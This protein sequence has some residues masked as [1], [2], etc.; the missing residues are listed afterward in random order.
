MENK[1]FDIIYVDS[2]LEFIKKRI[3]SFNDKVDLFVL[4]SNNPIN[5]NYFEEFNSK[6]YTIID[7][8]TTDYIKL[9]ESNFTKIV[10][11]LSPNHLDVFLVSN[12]NEVPDIDLERYDIELRSKPICHF[13]MVN[14]NL[15]QF[16]MGTVVFTF[17][18]FL[19]VT[20]FL[21]WITDEKNK[22]NAGNYNKIVSGTYYISSELTETQ[23][24]YDCFVFN[25]ELDLLNLRL[26]LLNEKVTKF[27]LVES[28]KSHSGEDKPL[29]FQEN[30]HLFSEYLSKITHIIVD[31]F[32][33][34]M[35]YSP[36]E[37]DVDPKLHIHWFRE[38]YQRNEILKGLYQESIHNND[39]I[40]ISD[41]DEIPDPEKLSSFISLIPEGEYRIQLQKWFCW[42]SERLYPSSWPGTSAIRWIDLLKTTPQDIRK[43]RYESSKILS[44]DHFGWHCSWFGGIDKVMEKLKTFAH[45]EL[46]NIDREDVL[47]KMTMNLDIH[48]QQLFINNDGYK[49]IVK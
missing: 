3:K 33:K 30:K 16:W 10:S 29:Y 41:L 2:D 35:I 24:I 45:Q 43:N 7:N 14:N 19:G 23:K 8:S 21:S 28:K 5:S 46:R 27:I 12:S 13:M 37:S 40:L 17:S 31:D 44:D 18:Q 36:S 6:I 39:I 32:P 20:N 38:N 15:N 9:I 26:S 34:E 49:P 22:I 1:I 47:K 42:D 4:I 25:N 11:H 48:G